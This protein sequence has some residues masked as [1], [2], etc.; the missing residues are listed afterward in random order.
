MNSRRLRLA[1]SQTNVDAKL[2]RITQVLELIAAL[3]LEE[4]RGERSVKEMIFALKKLGQQPASIARLLGKSSTH[5]R[6]EL[7]RPP[8]ARK[9][10]KK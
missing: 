9:K 8:K 6:S 10:G 4:V 3:K 2:E 1:D 5:V 7:A